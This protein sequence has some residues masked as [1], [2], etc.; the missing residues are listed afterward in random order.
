MPTLAGHEIDGPTAWRIAV[1]AV[2]V[3]GFVLAYLSTGRIAV[4]IVLGFLAAIG[5]AVAVAAV[6]SLVRAIQRG[7]R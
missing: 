7:L 3:C 5:V 1:L 2:V 6:S 4:S